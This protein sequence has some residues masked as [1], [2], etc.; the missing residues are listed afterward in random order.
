LPKQLWFHWTRRLSEQLDHPFHSPIGQR[1]SL[2]DQL[3]EQLCVGATLRRGVL[4]QRSSLV[5][6]KTLIET[7]EQGYPWPNAKGTPEELVA[8]SK[9]VPVFIA[10]P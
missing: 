10:G 2:L 3:L 1:L 9:F 4:D 6:S 8:A 7:F 5:L